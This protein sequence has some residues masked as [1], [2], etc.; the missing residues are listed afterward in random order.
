[1]NCSV[2]YTDCYFSVEEDVFGS[3]FESTDE[4]GEVQ[5]IQGERDVENEEK[6]ARKV[7]HNVSS[8]ANFHKSSI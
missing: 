7:I 4:E 5:S 6:K 1:L 3:D 2:I 8:F